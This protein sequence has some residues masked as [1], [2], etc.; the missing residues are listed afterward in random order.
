M[1]VF[2]ALSFVSAAD[3]SIEFSQIGD[4]IVVKEIIDGKSLGSY[5]DKNLLDSSGSRIYFVK[6][7]LFNQSFENAEIILKLDRGV[8]L[9]EE[10]VY[11]S[12]YFIETDGQIIEIVWEIKNA[13]KGQSFAIFAELEDTKKN[14]MRL[15]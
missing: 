15:M 6:K 11:P 5:V 2:F 14:L 7:L 4:K 13:S 1:L 9:G 3:Y 8:I 10:I 12:G